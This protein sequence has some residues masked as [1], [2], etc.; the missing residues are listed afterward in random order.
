MTRILIDVN[1]V[2][3]VLA[4]REPFAEDS[5]AV[6]AEVEAGSLQGYL[7]A[8]TVTTLH[9]LLT[10]HL[11]KARAR[12]ALS[13]LLSLVELVPV[14]QDRIRHALAADWADFEDAVQAACA[15]KAGVDYLVTRNKRDFKK[16]AIKAVTP[17]ELLA[18]L[19]S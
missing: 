10:R 3:D 15:E 1:V 18:L 13:D 11:G 17:A 8:H 6:L 12:R 16:S 2:L 7:A 5:A 19:P 9:F 4:D 14:D